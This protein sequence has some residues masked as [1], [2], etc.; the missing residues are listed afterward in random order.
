VDGAAAAAAADSDAAASAAVPAAAAAVTSVA[1]EKKS[2]AAAVGSNRQKTSGKLPRKPLMVGTL[3]SPV[4]DCGNLRA[5]KPLFGTASFIIDNV[6]PAMSVDEMEHFIKRKLRVRLLKINYT[7]PRRNGYEIRNNIKPTDRKA[8]FVCINKADSDLLIRGDAW[9]DDVYIDHWKFKNKS[10][11][12]TTAA[13]AAAAA[14]ATGKNMADGGGAGD[15][16]TAAATTGSS[17][18]DGASSAG[19]V[20]A[21]AAAASVNTS[22]VANNDGIA[23]A[24][25]VADL[26]ANQDDLPADKRYTNGL[27]TPPKIL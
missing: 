13:A 5:A 12:T 11:T 20:A 6:D 22:L 25:V 23:A 24:A 10:K 1:V 15:V 3:R 7:N 18:A 9:R 2:F 16:V 4:A 14:T 21:V 26:A 8:F 17:T 19:V 27:S